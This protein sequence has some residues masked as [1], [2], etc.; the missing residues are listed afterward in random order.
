MKHDVAILIITYNSENQIEECLDSVYK[1]N[2]RLSQEV[3][4]VDNMSQDGT[5]ELIRS[6]YPQ[7]NLIEPGKNLGFAAGV[8]L[9][10]KNANA[11]FI[12]LLNPDTVV[13]NDAVG[14]AHDFALE[15]PQ[16][17]FYGGRT[18]KPDMT[19]EASSCWG[20]PSLWS[21]LMFALG[22]SS[23]AKHNPILDPESLGNWQRDTVR[24]VGIITGCFLLVSKEAWEKIDGF[25]ERYWMYGED[26]DLAM[27][28][29]ASGYKP[30]ICPK[31]EVIHEVGQSSTSSSKKIML[32]KGKAS[33]T[34]IHWK[35][36]KRFLG[37]NLLV[38]GVALRTFAYKILNKKTE[39][40]KAWA[41]A[42]HL[43]KEWIQG[44]PPKS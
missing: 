24:E 25:D 41:E 5:V 43:R 29:R 36:L 19:L 23:F 38:L 18:L 28:A 4:V 20:S 1:E 31:A 3:I 14:I 26:A 34:R 17:G 7:V 39:S 8:N 22:F 16:Y 21:Y 10:A 33:Y 40:S 44:Y 2:K 11:N 27:R 32:Y 15:N 13:L 12:L 35:G 9:A 30:V 42:W 6:K 37:L